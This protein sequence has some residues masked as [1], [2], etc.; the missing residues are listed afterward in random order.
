MTFSQ[1]IFL[2]N[3]K[4]KR[5]K[6]L[7]YIK[8]QILNLHANIWLLKNKFGNTAFQLA[9]FESSQSGIII[10]WVGIQ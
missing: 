7:F 2:L 6:Y 9:I 3:L 1:K 5:I 8:L 10:I 4:W